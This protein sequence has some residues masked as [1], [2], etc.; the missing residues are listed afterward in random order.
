MLFAYNQ[1]TYRIPKDIVG[2]VISMDDFADLASRVMK[3]RSE[4]MEKIADDCI[5][6]NEFDGRCMEEMVSGPTGA[7]VADLMRAGFM[8]ILENHDISKWVTDIPPGSI[9]RHLHNEIGQGFDVENHCM[10]ECEDC[11]IHRMEYME[12]IKRVKEISAKDVHP[13]GDDLAFMIK[14]SLG[15]AGVELSSNN[16]DIKMFLREADGSTT[17]I[18]AEEV[19]AMLAASE[20]T[21]PKPTHSVSRRLN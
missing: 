2:E 21:I 16:P 1:K 18:S 15:E 12:T 3:S 8:Y 6:E 9:T 11:R 19:M 13:T 20:E 4:R 5:T 10:V 7:Y 17:A 14:F